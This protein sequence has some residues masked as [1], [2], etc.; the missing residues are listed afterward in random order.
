MGLAVVNCDSERGET[1]PMSRS[2][3]RFRLAATLIGAVGRS[4]PRR[5]AAALVVVG[6]VC[7]AL[8]GCGAGTPDRGDVLGDLADEVIAP[9]YER[10]AASTQALAGATAELCSTLDP[11]D[12]AAASRALEEAR[13]DWSY[14]EAMW[15][16]PVMERRSWAVIDWPISPA[17][18]E[19][20]IADTA[21]EIDYDRLARRIGADQRGLGA[22]D[23][24]LGP[25]GAADLD[26]LADPRRCAYLA[27]V[28]EV[29]AA[30][31]ALLPADWADDFEDEGPYRAVFTDPDGSGLD[32][33]VND[34]VF[35]LEAITD[36]ELGAAL[37]EMG[38]EADPS[39]IG[40]GPAGLG[41]ADLV[42]RLEGLRAVLIGPDGAGGLS[43]LLG[44]DLTG[45]LAARF[46]SA[47]AAVAAIEPPLLDAVATSPQTV[48]AARAAIK[49]LQITIVTEVVSR[50]G[51]TIGFSDADGD[52]GA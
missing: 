44:D 29:A 51:V 14:S 31:A 9:A 48:S 46:A 43:P 16:G 32:D 2:G 12:W 6:A 25:P 27:G 17:E 39:R 36:L 34:A 23:Y 7:V 18:I 41:A 47:A 26:D 21:V 38:R 4:A 5:L 19:D 11:D 24:L 28:A 20:L 35:L 10:L 3:I 49:D 8:A 45:R 1:G 33:V 42:D 13:A 22:V 52:T 30:E 37:G 50:L 40:E 15:V